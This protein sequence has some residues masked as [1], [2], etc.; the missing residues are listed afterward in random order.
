MVHAFGRALET[1]REDDVHALSAALERL[2]EDVVRDL[3]AESLET[4][5]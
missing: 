4:A 3:T 2:R 1:W 5:A